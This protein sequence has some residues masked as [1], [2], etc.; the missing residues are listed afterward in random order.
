MTTMLTLWTL[1]AL[2]V[3]I[4]AVAYA[5]STYG[6]IMANEAGD[7]QMQRIAKSIQDGARA[8]LTAEYRWLVWFAGGV[9]ILMLV[10]NEAFGIRQAVPFLLGGTLSAIA[11]YFGMHCST[12]SGVRTTQA[13]KTSLGKALD[14]AFKS[15]SFMGLIVVG[16]GLAGITVLM[17]I[18]NLIW[19]DY[20]GIN[21]ILAFSFG[22][23]SIALFAR[24]G[25]GIY[26][27]AADVGGDLVGKLE[28]G[29]PEDDP[30]NP[31]VIADNVG[32]NVGDVAGMGADLYESYVGAILST[33]VLALFL[34]GGTGD[35]LAANK[36]GLMAYPL[37]LAALGIAASI[38]GM[39]K[40]KAEH[41]SE[42]GAALFRGLWMASI[43]LIVLMIPFTWIIA[44]KPL[45]ANGQ[46]AGP[47]AVYLS[48]VAGLVAG[49]LIGKVTEYYTSDQRPPV[50]GIAQQST[51]GPATNIIAGLATGMSSTWLP[52]L[53][54]AISIYLCDMWAGVYGICIAAV[55][56]LSTL[57]ISL[58]V[59]AYGP[60][61]D[62]AGGM[63][64]MT[65]CPPEVRKRTDSL[66]ATGNMTAAI[67][68]GFAIGSAALTAL[69]LFATY[70]QQAEAK[71]GT[72]I[73]LSLSDSMVVMG[74]LIGAML[75]F[76][77]CAKA[78]QAVGRA[79]NAMVEEVRRQFREIP[80]LLEG[81]AEADYARCVRIST[82]GA[83][84]QMVAPGL[85]AVV[86][87]VATGLIFGKAAVAG[88]LAG[89]LCTGVMLALFMANAG[90][91]WDNAKKYIEGG[92]HGGK[93]SPVHK[94][95][96]IGDT[97]GDPF[98]DTAGP[99][100]NILIK[101]MSI[102]AVLAV[103]LFA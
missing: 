54:I 23:S 87:P 30:R 51:T 38:W 68:K 12:R 50:R 95:A 72:P 41:E 84:R 58:G 47:W 19:P 42:L 22:A 15:G 101:L 39:T 69:A 29:I 86:A 16:L 61:A 45:L 1:L 17:L 4:G 59:D 96:V 71:T 32:D 82:E 11:G 76:L 77:F 49:V 85:L 52:V 103:P 60:V 31:A 25:G 64:Q 97:V 98:K 2:A 26:T 92:A 66:D 10:F 3:A 24:V 79:A 91:A 81:K 34:A 46:P 74:L 21:D 33:V 48:M 75:P 7:D 88:L 70:Q 37:V 83:L 6:Q 62:N 14:I 102:A 9:V 8:F 28:A 35:E 20:S 55:G 57:G 80:G 65:N 53:L 94:A 78:M 36:I 100:L 93:G 67:G 63:A 89:S 99:S 44:P 5:R 27:K 56:M 18:Y 43:A 40:V 90:G 13:A 73:S